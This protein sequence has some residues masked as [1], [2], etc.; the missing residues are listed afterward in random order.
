MSGGHY[1][2]DELRCL[3]IAQKINTDIERYGKEYSKKTISKM[4][5]AQHCLKRSYKMVKLIDLFVSDDIGEDDFLK[6]WENKVGI[7]K[8]QITQRRRNI[9]DKNYKKMQE[10]VSEKIDGECFVRFNAYEGEID[11]ENFVNNLNEIALKGKCF[12][13]ACANWAANDERK[14][15][16]SKT[17]EDPTW[18]D[19]CVIANDM[20]KT[21]KDTHHIYLEGIQKVYEYFDNT[22]QYKFL[23][24]S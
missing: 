8:N 15:F 6:E 3:M 4:V 2:G 11:K 16:I 20:I 22:A 18:L 19:I 21:T 5:E 23:M 14:N 12:F 1:N 9:M 17:V 7:C 24:G 10:Q 13:V